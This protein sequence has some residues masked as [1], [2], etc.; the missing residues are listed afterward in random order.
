MPNS[1]NVIKL[2]ASPS[3]TKTY[4]YTQNQVVKYVTET[5]AELKVA[6][7][8]QKT[9]NLQK[10]IDELELN[11]SN[12]NN[13]LGTVNNNLETINSK[14]NTLETVDTEIK[15]NI[16]TIQ[17]NIT[18]I[19][20]TVNELSE[21]VD[22]IKPS[23]DTKDSVIQSIIPANSTTAFYLPIDE[24]KN[25]EIVVEKNKLYKICYNLVMKAKSSVKTAMVTVDIVNVNGSLYQATSSEFEGNIIVTDK[26]DMTAETVW[27][28]VKLDPELLGNSVICKISN[29]NDQDITCYSTVRVSKVD[30]VESSE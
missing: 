25:T 12:V 22:D 1:S 21:K 5:I 26:N 7:L 3:G 16:G 28:G 4:F 19:Q 24:N 17:N 23:E 29:T 6:E 27:F 20:N 13:S 9:E 10:Q 11:V 14:I 30:L 15:E 8:R 2:S 18:S